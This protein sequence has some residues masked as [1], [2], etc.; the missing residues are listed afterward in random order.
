MNRKDRSDYKTWGNGY[1]HLSSE[2]W[3]EGK[4]FHNESHFAY[5]MTLLGILT[6]RFKIILYD[7]VLMD[8]HIHILLSGTGDEC[9]MAFDYF[10]KKLTAYLLKDGFAPLPREYGFKL[11]PVKEEKQ[12]RINFLYLDRNVLERRISLPGG[13]SLELGLSSLFLFV[14]IHPRRSRQYL[15]Q[16]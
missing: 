8:N 15:L 9:T 10:K 2:G 13:V 7:F 6:L 16:T 1:Y 14:E 5:G 11:T 12:M 4:L 3:K